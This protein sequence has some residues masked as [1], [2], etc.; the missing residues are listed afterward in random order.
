MRKTVRL[1]DNKY[2]Q[3]KIS[4]FSEMRG[5]K[6]AATQYFMERL[7]ADGERSVKAAYGDELKRCYHTVFGEKSEIKKDR[8][9]YQWFGQE[10][11]KREPH[12]WINHVNE[13]L[14]S[15]P[16]FHQFISDMRQPNEYEDLK[17]QGFRMVRIWSPEYMRVERMKAAGEEV[18]LEYFRHETEQHIDNFAFDDLILN[19]GTLEDLY[20]KLDAL[21]ER[22][23]EEESK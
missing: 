10:M 12:V 2:K 1:R 18:K 22:I 5:G 17:R 20:K 6:D 3:I 14:D 9:G 8:D 15:Y 13:L 4:F 23:I 11:R 21:Y 16:D 19:I 7:A